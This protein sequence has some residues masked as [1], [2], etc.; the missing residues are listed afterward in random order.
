MGVKGS[1]RRPRPNHLKALDGVAE[2]R[3]NR[4]EPLPAPAASPEP[5]DDL[6]T[7]AQHV[8]SSL[9]PGLIARRVLT[10]DDVEL[11]AAFCRSLA[12]YHRYAAEVERGGA[13]TAGYAGNAVLSPAFRAMNASLDQAVRLAARFG[14]TP[15]DRAGLRLDDPA[16][17][18]TPFGPSRLLD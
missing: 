17:A 4:D 5:P 3:I 9:A 12:L 14:L 16:G 6:P 10:A 8:W 13:Q 7:E 11:F 18:A 1:G 2:C 15:A